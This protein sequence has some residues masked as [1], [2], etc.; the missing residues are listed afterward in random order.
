MGGRDP[1]HLDLHGDT[2]Y[3]FGEESESNTAFLKDLCDN[4]D[5]LDYYENEGF[6]RVWWD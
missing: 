6:Y 4:Y 5:E 2:L 3:F 1:E